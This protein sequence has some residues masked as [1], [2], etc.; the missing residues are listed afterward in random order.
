M[1]SIVAEAMTP[2]MPGAGPPP[3]RIARVSMGEIP[4]RP[5]KISYHGKRS[6]WRNSRP[7]GH[8]GTS[9]PHPGIAVART[10]P[11]DPRHRDV[12]RRLRPADDQFRAARVRGV[13]AH[14]AG[15]DRP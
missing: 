9:G 5:G 4:I 13:V 12:L 14:V 2:L 10:R 15:A 11:A 1:A 3:T 8:L 6:G 7:D